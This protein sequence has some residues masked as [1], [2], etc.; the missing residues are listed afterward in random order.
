VV[1]RINALYEELVSGHSEIGTE[2]CT[3]DQGGSHCSTSTP[4]SKEEFGALLRASWREPTA[5]VTKEAQEVDYL[6]NPLLLLELAEAYDSNGA[7]LKAWR[8]WALAQKPMDN[9]ANR[10]EVMTMSSETYDGLAQIGEHVNLD[11]DEVAD[12][13]LTIDGVLIP[14]TPLGRLLLV[15]GEHQAIWKV[16]SR[17]CMRTFTIE[18]GKPNAVKLACEEEYLPK[19]GV[20]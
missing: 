19:L 17:T 5:R 11:I 7:H 20:P 10:A 13:T 1:D 15:V 4:L 14:G 18:P 16:K 9:C 6:E 3:S 2:S 8:M 12:G